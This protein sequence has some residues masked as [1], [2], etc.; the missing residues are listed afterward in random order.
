MDA[1]F[2]TN[3]HLYYLQT[4]QSLVSIMIVLLHDFIDRVFL[5][6]AISLCIGL[7]LKAI[8]YYRTF[9][10]FLYI[11]VLFY[12]LCL[13]CLCVPKVIEEQLIINIEEPFSSLTII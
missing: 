11:Y 8:F 10:L 12:V 6:K 2:C 7:E 5:K 4:T 9:L 3:V 13:L 1:V